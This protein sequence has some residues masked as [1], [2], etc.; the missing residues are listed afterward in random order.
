MGKE[1][2]PLESLVVIKKLFNFYSLLRSLEIKV[3]IQFVLIVIA[4]IFEALT[5]AVFLPLIIL[6]LNQS[7]LSGSLLDQVFKFFSFNNISLLTSFSIFVIFLFIIKFLYLNLYNY[8]QG[9]FIYRTENIISSILLRK[10][11]LLPLNQIEKEHSSKIINLVTTQSYRWADFGLKSIINLI[12]DIFLVSGLIFFLFILNPVP[13]I[14]LSL[15]ILFNIYF[16]SKFVK[17]KNFLWGNENVNLEQKRLTTLRETFSLLKNIKLHNLNQ[18]YINEFDNITKSSRLLI[19]KQFVLNNLPRLL[20]ELMA[21]IIFVIVILFSG[22]FFLNKDF[23]LIPSLAIIGA[24]AFRIIPA[25]GRIQGSLIN[26]QFA[27]PILDEIYLIMKIKETEIENSPAKLLMFNDKIELK[28][29]QFSYN[30]NKKIFKNLNLTIKKGKITGIIGPSGSGKS[31]LIN[32]LTGFNNPQKGQFF[33]DGKEN[34]FSSKEW[35]NLIGYVPQNI[36]ISNRSVNENIAIG[37]KK[38]SIDHE[39]IKKILKLSN[40]ENFVEELPYKTNQIMGENAHNI[41]GGQAQRIAIARSL[42]R[43][44]QILIFDE[45]TSSLDVASEDQ[46][47]LDLQNL[48]DLITIIVVTHRDNTLKFCDEIYNIEDLDK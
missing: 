1:Y 7:V 16:L 9:K 35:R 15:F 27:L 12:A 25:I 14:F 3:Y 20:I 48:K 37:I 46:I 41:S 18:F 31:S 36:F 26:I 4:T 45:S 34:N 10:F 33:I 17:N 5:I 2:C 22:Y 32:I 23:N 21:V 43:Q 8:Y 11:L 29:I 42:Y 19:A 40:L 30:N 24:S 28:N 38:E 6:L 44:P 47:L 13:V 39:V